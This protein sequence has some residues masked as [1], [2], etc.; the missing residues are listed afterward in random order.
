MSELKSF[1]EI[2]ESLKKLGFKLDFEDDEIRA[3]LNH[4][5]MRIVKVIYENLMI[6]LVFYGNKLFFVHYD[7]VCINCSSINIYL[8]EFE[9]PVIECL[10]AESTKVA[11]IYLDVVII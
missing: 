5:D 4:K 6:A 1:D 2:T 9:V 11:E 10:N 3:C 8:N 7:R